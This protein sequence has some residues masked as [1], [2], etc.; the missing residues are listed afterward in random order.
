MKTSISMSKQR[1]E[2]QDIYF[3]FINEN[4]KRLRKKRKI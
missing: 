3:K 1:N 2:K 4:K